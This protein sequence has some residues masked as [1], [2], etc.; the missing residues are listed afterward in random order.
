MEDTKQAKKK[1]CKRLGM[2][3]EQ[4]ERVVV[5]R[6]LP[7]PLTPD[8]RV[9]DQKLTFQSSELKCESFSSPSKKFRK[10][11]ESEKNSTADIEISKNELGL[12]ES[13]N[14]EIGKRDS[15]CEGIK[16]RKA[17]F[18]ALAA[19]YEA[20]EYEY[21]PAVHRNL[22]P[23]RTALGTSSPVLSRN[24]R[25][26]VTSS[27]NDAVKMTPENDKISYP[28]E[29][30]ELPKNCN[31]DESVVDDINNERVV[32]SVN[33]QYQ[34][35][36]ERYTEEVRKDCGIEAFVSE[37]PYINDYVINSPYKF[38]KQ[39]SD[40]EGKK[41]EKM[42]DEQ[43][44]INLLEEC[45]A[46]NAD[47]SPSAFIPAGLVASLTK[48]F[49]GGSQLPGP[50]F[51]P[52]RKFKVGTSGE[53]VDKAAVNEKLECAIIRKSP[54]REF[55]EEPF[56]ILNDKVKRLRS[57]WEKRVEDADVKAEE[58]SNKEAEIVPSDSSDVE[59]VEK[60][61]EECERKDDSIIEQS[62][63][64]SFENCSH[65][66]SVANNVNSDIDYTCT[67]SVIS[68][69]D[70]M[71]TPVMTKENKPR[72]SSVLRSVSSYRN[73]VKNYMSESTPHR[74]IYKLPQ[75]K[76]EDASDGQAESMKLDTLLENYHI[77]ADVGI[78]LRAALKIQLE[79]IHQAS[80]ALNLCQS[81]QEFRGSREEV[82]AQK[83]LLL[84][85]ERKKC[86]DQELQRMGI[87]VQNRVDFQPNCPLGTLTVSHISIPLRR[88]WVNDN[89]NKTDRIMYYFICLLK[90]RETVHAT[91]MVTSDDGK[92]AG[93][94]EFTN[95]FQFTHLPPDFRVT[96]ELYSLVCGTVSI[97]GPSGLM[98]TRF[99]MVGQLDIC[100]ETVQRTPPVQGVVI[101]NFRCCAENASAVKE[102]GLLNVFDDSKVPHVWHLYYGVLAE[103]VL[104]FWRF[105][106]DIQKEP[107]KV[108]ELQSCINEHVRAESEGLSTRNNLIFLEIPN[109]ESSEN[110]TY[111]HIFSADND[112]EYI[113][114]VDSLERA[115]H[116]TRL[117]RVDDGM[118]TGSIAL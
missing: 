49:E 30:V 87:C 86:I 114:W 52:S 91:H 76:N 104:K 70:Q 18:K 2:N 22:P 11:E 47:L 1:T 8:R 56:E 55:A 84:S 78:S 80:R 6:F 5:D 44:N 75:S 12:N 10:Q 7:M 110:T 93:R 68:P 53:K 63:D 116:H 118:K 92:Q 21:K 77:K 3:E 113:R 51:V 46:K 42:D 50:R 24:W 102:S 105:P 40:F 69:E 98:D 85:T 4:A 71:E 61:E 17:R 26:V 79:Q 32:S 13:C 28:G 25:N 82:D 83:A 37:K 103:G 16:S 34:S 35:P 72:G 62:Q 29:A 99:N 94:L 112:E 97:G 101:L 96:L 54:Q 48:Q 19:E 20:F 108:I 74:L 57:C 117:W 106:E 65:N 41:T 107:L 100:L 66:S 59:T 58:T 9:S 33:L 95:Y 73:H 43:S 38:L 14:A 111:K 88:D 27:E 64:D 109:L 36:V 15:P 31:Q 90:Y 39:K 115:L 81:M 60:Y 23:R 45:R 89:I 67:S